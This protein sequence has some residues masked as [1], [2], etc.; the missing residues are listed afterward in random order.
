VSGDAAAG[1]AIGIARPIA[2]TSASI[3]N[4]SFFIFLSPFF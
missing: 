4:N 2:R 1:T 3:V